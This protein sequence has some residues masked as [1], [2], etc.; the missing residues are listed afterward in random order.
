MERR[1]EGMESFLGGQLVDS[2]QMFP[3][4]VVQRGRKVGTVAKVA[5]ITDSEDEARIRSV[6]RRRAWRVR[7]GCGWV[8]RRFGGAG[9]QLRGRVASAHGQPL[10]CRS[11]TTTAV[12]SK[13]PSGAGPCQGADSVPMDPGFV[14]L[15]GIV[16]A[17]TPK[18]N[19]SYF[20]ISQKAVPG[21]GC[22]AP[23]Y[24]RPRFF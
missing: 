16:K 14:F 2:D 12:T 22:S 21:V 20:Y 1:S 19:A 5:G 23:R 9:R 3:D 4:D 17:D 11:G 6:G 7:A 15:K 8:W 18:F 10:R 24:R 13:Y